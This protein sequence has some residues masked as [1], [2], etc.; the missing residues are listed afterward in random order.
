M[1]APCVALNGPMAGL[2]SDGSHL[3]QLRKTRR[4]GNEMDFSHFSQL[5]LAYGSEF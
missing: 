4:K 3:P 2:M 1:V 5:H